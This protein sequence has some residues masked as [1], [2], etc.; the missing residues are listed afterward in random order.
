MVCAE[1]AV[2]WIMNLHKALFISLFTLFFAACEDEKVPDP[3]PPGGSSDPGQCSILENG[4]TIPVNT[5][6]DGGVGK[7]GIPSIENPQFLPA[8]EI[9][10][11]T[12][13]ELVIVVKA[14]NTMKAYPQR[15]LDS[16]EV[17]N[18]VIEDIP[19]AITFCPLTGTAIAFERTINGEVTTLGV[20]GLLY[21]SNLILYDRQTDTRW[22]Q[23]TYRGITGELSCASLATIPVVE[24]AWSALRSVHPDIAVLTNDTGFDRDYNNLPESSIIILNS[25][26]VFPYEP[27]D[28]RLPNYQRV[29]GVL[30]S[31]G[32]TAYT[33]DQIEQGGHVFVNNNHLL[34][35]DPEAKFIAAY[36]A[37]NGRGGFEL[38]KGKE[39]VIMKDNLG[40]EYD[41]FGTVV[42]GPDQDDRLV[43]TN[44]YV[45]YWFAMAAMQPD[46][47]IFSNE[48]D[49]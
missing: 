27:R 21:N 35:V 4:W 10:G 34:V 26:P 49:G 16:H 15:I 20:S 44:S 38:V 41:L 17:V 33:L 22:S 19:V 46:I 29:L 25:L 12:A 18:D 36:N 8:G 30:D 7:D 24:I 37:P 23:M 31:P 6:A 2:T 47:Q 28:S 48:E 43:P 42:S 5:V 3:I 11:L 45:G 40:N 39:G 1:Y 32:A 9:T 14:G 13:D